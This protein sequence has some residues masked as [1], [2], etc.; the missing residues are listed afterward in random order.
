MKRHKNTRIYFEYLGT[1]HFKN[2]SQIYSSKINFENF[3]TD[4]YS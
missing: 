1:S 2:I 3:K 4:I